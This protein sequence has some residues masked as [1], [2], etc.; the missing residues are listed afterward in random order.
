MHTI[1]APKAQL[2]LTEHPKLVKQKVSTACS[3]DS[4]PGT[5]LISPAAATGALGDGAS[6]KDELVH[7]S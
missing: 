2:A 4:F 6:T 5:R 1:L 7:A 3:R